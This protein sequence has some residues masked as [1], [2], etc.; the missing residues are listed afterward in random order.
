[1]LTKPLLNELKE[2]IKKDYKKEFSD[3][4]ISEI[5]N[6]LVNYFDLLAKIDYRMKEKVKSPDLLPILKK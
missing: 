5:G 6:N 4:E 2:I 1:M 3:K